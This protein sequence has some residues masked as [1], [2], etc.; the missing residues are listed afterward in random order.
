MNIHTVKRATQGLA[1]HMLKIKSDLSAA[2]AYDS[3]NYSKEFADY[4]ASVLTAKGIKVYLFEDLRPTPELS[5]AIRELS[6]D[7]SI[8]ITASH[9]PKKY[10]SYKVYG[11]DG[12]QITLETANS[13]IEEINRLDYFDVKSIAIKEAID[14]GK[15][16][17]LGQGMNDL[18]LENVIGLS[19]RKSLFDDNLL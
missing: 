12:G 7:V 13:V 2:I 4:A 15:L 18:Y 3:R 16:K 9:N 10:N 11:S 19:K 6:Y 1:N 8:V 5:F 17:Y 14:K